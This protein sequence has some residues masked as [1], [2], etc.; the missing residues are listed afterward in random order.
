M[1]TCDI[2]TDAKLKYSSKKLSKE[3]SHNGSADELLEAILKKETGI[4]TDKNI[5][6]LKDGAIQVNLMPQK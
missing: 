4:F 3:V 1:E 5:E 2:V 6:D